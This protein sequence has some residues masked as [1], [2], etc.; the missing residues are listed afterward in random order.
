[1]SD[2][3]NALSGYQS[4]ERVAQTRAPGTVE[5][6]VGDLPFT[7][8]VFGDA[9]AS[10]PYFY[11]LIGPGGAAMTRSFPMRDLP[12]ET[13]DHPHHRSLWVAFGEVNEVD[14]WQDRANHGFT[15]H[16]SLDALDESD[17]GRMVAR[18]DWE[19]A[20]GTLLCREVLDVRIQPLTDGARLIDWRLT[21]TAPENQPVH[22]GDTKEG[23]L[24]ALRVATVLDGK[25]GGRIENAEGGVG[26]KECWGR[27]SRWCDYSGPHPDAKGAV[28][29][30]ALLDHP[31]SFR[32]PTGWHVRDYGLHTANPFAL[33]T[34]TRGAEDGSYHLPA[35]ESLQF[36]YAVLVHAGD[37]REGRVEEI[38]RA[39]S[40]AA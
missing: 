20:D 8:Y 14:N 21:L 34:F 39:W 13:T 33:G 26:E 6:T 15:R 36:H 10:R 4:D 38:W 31:E 32:H 25:Q 29:G 11:P 35:G 24:V 16:R 3:T 9:N 18:A 12:G 2:T 37:A 23:G 30:A 22:F 19:D 5:F 28:V 27:R 17:P 7:S 40:G 1:M